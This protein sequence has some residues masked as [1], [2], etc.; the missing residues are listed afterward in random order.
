HSSATDCGFPCAWLAV[1]RNDRHWRQK[2]DPREYSHSSCPNFL[3][4]SA[5]RYGDAVLLTDCRQGSG[6]QMTLVL[7]LLLPGCDGV[8]S[9]LAPAGSE[10]EM[11]HGIWWVLI[12]GAIVIWLALNGAFLFFTRIRP[13]PVH[14]R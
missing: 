11:L 4:L 8:Q 12:T 3:R 5:H 6:W 13:A 10:A 7:A 1:A 14:R 2:P 9:A